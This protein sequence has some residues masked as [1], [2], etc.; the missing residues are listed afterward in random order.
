MRQQPFNSS[1]KGRTASSTRRT[2]LSQ[3]A[4]QHVT[5]LS[6]FTTTGSQLLRRLQLQRPAHTVPAPSGTDDRC[7][8]IRIARAAG[9]RLPPVFNAQTPDIGEQP[10]FDVVDA[11]DLLRAR[12]RWIPTSRARRA[13]AARCTP[14]M[15]ARAGLRAL[16]PGAGDAAG[17][18]L[19]TFHHHHLPEFQSQRP[20]IEPFNFDQDFQFTPEP[21]SPRC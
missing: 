21:T 18:N 3:Q 1:R 7:Q 19:P 15:P 13:G 17:L 11:F 10:V 2:S 20:Q 8:R 9:S 14:S 16:Y 4:I 12:S 5:A 6:N